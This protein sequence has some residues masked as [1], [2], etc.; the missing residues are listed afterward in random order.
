M[1]NIQAAEQAARQAAQAK[2]EEAAKARAAAEILKLR[3]KI[4]ATGEKKKEQGRGDLPKGGRNVRYGPDGS[5][6]AEDGGETPD[7]G[8]PRKGIDLRA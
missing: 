4:E 1:M 3:E 7:S 8:P 2:A 5:V 6:Q